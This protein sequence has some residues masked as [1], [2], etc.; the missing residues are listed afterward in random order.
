MYKLYAVCALVG[1][2]LAVGPTTP[3]SRGNLS[4]MLY[5]LNIIKLMYHKIVP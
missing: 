1:V 4:I 2:V 5:N 3:D